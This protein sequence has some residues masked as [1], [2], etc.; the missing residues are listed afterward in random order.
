[1]ELYSKHKWQVKDVFNV[2]VG[3][4]ILEFTLYLILQLSG[5]RE[6]FLYLQENTILAGVF[7]FVMYLLQTLGMLLPFWYFVVRKYGLEI[8]QLGFRWIGFWKTAAWIVAAYIVYIG[9]SIFVITLFSALGIGL[10]GFEPQQ[11][12]FEF[13]GTDIVG[14]VFAGFVAIVLA[15]FV[16][17]IFFRGFVLNT[18]VKRIGIGWGIVLTA[19]VFAAVHFEFQSIVPLIIL[20]FVLN[21]LYVRT[22]SIWPGILFHIANNTIAFFVLL[23]LSH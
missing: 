16:E 22:N 8:K 11:S 13:F 9:L 21:V 7:L 3:T 2:F 17:E 15:P 20:A 23:L 5:A 1:M 14:I 12:I 10:L 19:L 4:F 18:L 6:Y